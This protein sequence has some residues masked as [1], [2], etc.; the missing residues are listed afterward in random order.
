MSWGPYD[1][2][3]CNYYPLARHSSET[4]HDETILIWLLEWGKGTLQE[5]PSVEIW[6][7]SDWIYWRRLAL[8]NYNNPQVICRLKTQP[9]PLEL[10]PYKHTHLI[11]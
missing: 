2:N 8:E 1:M 11:I 4:E 7:T 10:P 3:V 9:P 5:Y 6:H